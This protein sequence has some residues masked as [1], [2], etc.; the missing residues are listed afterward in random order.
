MAEALRRLRAFLVSRGAHV[1][2]VHLEPQSDGR[3]TGLDDALAAGVTLADLA[4][5]ST[6]SLRVTPA[7][8]NDRRPDLDVS[9]LQRSVALQAFEHLNRAA[10]VY[11]TGAGLVHVVNDDG[12]RVLRP[13]GVPDL[14]AV[15]DQTVR[16]RRGT[17]EGQVSCFPPR[18][19]AEI[20]AHDPAPPVPVLRAVVT[21]PTFTASGRL[22]DRPGY[23]P[24]A[25]LLLVF[26]WTPRDVPV[27][28]SVGDIEA[29]RALWDADALRDFPFASDADR[30]A[31]M[32]LAL[33]PMVRELIDGPTP[34]FSVE[35]PTRGAGKG[36]LLSTC[37]YPTLGAGGWVG[38]AF[39]RED[40]EV[41]KALTTYLNER[42]PAIVFEN[43]AGAVRSSALAKA[44]TDRIWDDRVLGRTGSVRCPVRCL[45]A[46]TANN[47]TW[48]DELA[49]RVVPVRLVPETD[50]PE[51]RSG[52][53]HPELEA[54]VADHRADLLWAL[55]VFVR[56]WQ[57]AHC[58]PPSVPS[59]GSFEA[60]TRV[61]GGILET[62]GYRDFLGN[63]QE[64]L[65]A[66]DP[67]TATWEAFVTA[68]WERHADSLVAVRELLGLAETQGVS[69]NG[70]TE[71]AQTTS[72]GS[73]LGKR[74]DRFFGPYQIRQ[75]AG[76]ARREWRLNRHA[77]TPHDTYDTCDTPDPGLLRVARARAAGSGGL[78][79]AEVS[80]VSRGVAGAEEATDRQA[81]LFA[82]LS[83]NGN[84]PPDLD[85]ADPD[86]VARV[87]LWEDGA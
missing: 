50:R 61:V 72:L 73:A 76:G 35:A 71:R 53:L 19:L 57:H 14:R 27:E 13:L 4:G 22:L 28:P 29:A 37:L 49:R 78:E 31:A 82:E 38:A 54:W 6:E 56:G 81:S 60:W 25:K 75:G 44:I 23:D 10:A 21:A 45:W 66:A 8:P 68:W 20:M 1:R 52:F 18:D 77:V 87:A 24:S 33:T 79:V 69:V 86:E 26:D 39:P 63:R 85:D 32:A 2:I 84:G 58:P 67:G 48:S 64:I 30:T 9:V 80:R 55:A 43:V 83:G 40:E 12:V 17:Q 42:R 7:A 51:L 3:K 36:K 47:P 74:R 70:E 62:A 41:R 11:Q 46:V 15:L 16:C 5:A 59:L 65:S 34:L